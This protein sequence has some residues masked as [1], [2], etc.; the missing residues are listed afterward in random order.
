MV[1]RLIISAWCGLGVLILGPAVATAQPVADRRWQVEFIGG[2]SVFDLPTSGTAAL[3]PQG[4][5]LPT[6]G[7]TNPSRRVPTWFLGDGASLLNGTN[8][9]FGVPS[10]LVPLDDALGGVGLS[11]SGAPVVGVRIHRPF[12]TRWSVELAAEL[13][14]GSADLDPELIEAVELARTGFAAAFEGLF[15]TGPFTAVAVESSS[16]IQGRSSRELLVSGAVRRTW[17]GRRFAPYVVVGGGV[18]TRVGELP[19]VALA[20]SY[21]F[22]V[23][24]SQGQATFAESDSLT[25]RFEQGAN[26]LGIAGAG[27]VRQVSDR[28]SLTLDGRAYLGAETLTVRL[29]SAPSVSTRTPGA[30][31]ESFTTPAVQF[32]N[33]SSTGRDS[34]LSG[35]PLNGFKAFTTGGLQVRYVI[36]AGAM[37]R[38]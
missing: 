38:F 3:P 23:S 25:V 1:R 4:P 26:L 15:T 12:G 18:M 9:E 2:L 17:E 35:T 16:A 10:R 13:H 11:G 7:P 20:G 36:T 30:F 14:T 34:T 24:T 6:S 19:R 27:I 29:D 28:V 5:S 8:A 32:S 21:Q 22:A 33:N 31:I 37:I